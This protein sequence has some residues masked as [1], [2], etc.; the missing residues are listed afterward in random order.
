[1]RPAALVLAF[2]AT[3]ACTSETTV[4]VAP[5]GPDPC[6]G[7]PFRVF[8]RC[9]DHADSS[10]PVIDGVNG[11]SCVRVNGT[12]RYELTFRAPA[13]PD[14]IIGIRISGS[15]VTP[16]NPWET[17]WSAAVTPR[18]RLAYTFGPVSPGETKLE[19]QLIDEQGKYGPPMC[20]DVSV[21]E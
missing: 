4:P 6:E 7:E 16:T 12:G 8:E 15:L 5:V 20:G 18:D 21:R 17:R 1:M 9:P 19:L 10:G 11:P 14:R 2:G 13:A 3:T